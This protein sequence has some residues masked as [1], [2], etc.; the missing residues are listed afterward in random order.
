[1][2]QNPGYSSAEI[3]KLREECEAEGQSFVMVEDEL[4]LAD[5]GEYLQFQFIGKYEGKEVIYDAALFTLE[6]HYQS[7]LMELAEQRVAKMHKGFVPLD[8]RK[9]GYKAKPEIDELVQEFME[10]IEEEDS[11]KVAEFIELDTDFEFGIGLEVALNVE[12]INTE[13]ITQF[14]ESFNAGTFKPDANLYSF[15]QEE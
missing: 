2:Q 14:I 15:K 6:L 11:L 9:P 8:E 13:V 3:E 4:E 5:S 12:E 1:M 7:Q 10:E